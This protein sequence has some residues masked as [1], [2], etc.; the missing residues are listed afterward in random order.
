MQSTILNV[1]ALSNDAMVFY[2]DRPNH[3]IWV[4]FSTATLR[5]CNCTLHIKSVFSQKISLLDMKVQDTKTPCCK[6]CNRALEWCTFCN[7]NCQSYKRIVLLSSGLYRRFRNFTESTAD[8]AHGLYHRFWITQYPEAWW[9][10]N[11]SI[12]R[13]N[14]FVKCFFGNFRNEENCLIFPQNQ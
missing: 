13:A 1:P 7:D 2:D 3:W 4:C 9:V 11:D 14:P 12:A 8:A 6:N 5:Q 10:T